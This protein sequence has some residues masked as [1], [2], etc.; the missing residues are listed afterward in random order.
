MATNSGQGFT[1]WLP[2]D[3]FLAFVHVVG[4][5]GFLFYLSYCSRH[6]AESHCGF[7]RPSLVTH[8]EFLNHDVLS[9]YK[10]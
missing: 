2:R 4:W 9:Q 1:S 5:T 10:F 3:V 6:D 8:I 7:D